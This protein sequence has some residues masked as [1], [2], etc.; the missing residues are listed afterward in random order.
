MLPD[1]PNWHRALLDES[2]LDV[3]RVRPAV[4]R[5]STAHEI[6]RY[7]GFRYRFR[8]LYLFDLEG[9]QMRPLVESAGAACEAACADLCS[10]ADHLDALAD[11]L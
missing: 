8:N 9:T 7:L 2:A 6:G 11:A 1:G 4:L 10:F 3:P 5:S